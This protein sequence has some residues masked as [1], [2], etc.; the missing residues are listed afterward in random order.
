M[1]LFISH[2]LSDYQDNIFY[3]FRKTF[4]EEVVSFPRK[5]YYFSGHDG[6]TTNFFNFTQDANISLEDIVASNRAGQLKAVIIISYK[7]I[8]EEAKRILKELVKDGKKWPI[9]VIDGADDDRIAYQ[10][11][12]SYPVPFDFYFKR[13]YH[14]GIRNWHENHDERQ[15]RAVIET[16]KYA[17]NILPLPFCIIPEKF[18]KAQQKQKKYNVFFRCGNVTYSKNRLY[19]MHD[20][21]YPNS[22]IDLCLYPKTELVR[23]DRMEYFNY[24]WESKINLNLLGGGNDCYRVWEVLGVGGF[25]LNQTSDL[26][27]IPPLEDG[28]NCALFSSKREMIDKIDFYIK[29]DD[30]REQITKNGYEFVMRNHTCYNRMKFIIDTIRTKFVF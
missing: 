26:T 2:H 14:H 19:Y 13:E 9:V 16:G 17:G 5:D 27:I 4:G 15:I 7:T 29:Y 18:P 8:H 20:F 28:V 11:F 1:I 24:I 10:D 3:A 6:Y 25:L 22:M 21:S 23:Q 12:D 30:I